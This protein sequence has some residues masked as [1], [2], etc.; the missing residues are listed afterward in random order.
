MYFDI[1][2]QREL[3]V[4]LTEKQFVSRVH[5]L[6]EPQMFDVDLEPVVEEVLEHWRK[7]ERT[8]TKNQL[9]Q[10]AAR[11]QVKLPQGRLNGFDFDVQEV[12][13]FAR[14]RLMRSAL[15]EATAYAEKGRFDKGIEAVTSLR[16]RFNSIGNNRMAPDILESSRPTPVRENVIS[17]G[18]DRLD[19]ALQGGVAA[20]NLAVALAP[21]SG[22]KTSFLCWLA[23]TAAEAGKKVYYVTLE[24]PATE[25]ESKLR[26][27]LTGVVRPSRNK[28]Q[29]TAKALAAKKARIRVQEHPPRTVSIDDLDGE[30]EEDTDLIL[31]DYAD[32]LRPPGGSAGIDYHDLGAIYANLKRVGLQRKVPIWTAS[33]VNRA[34]YGK[35]ELD[36]ED[37]EASL[38]KAMVSDQIVSLSQDKWDKPDKETGNSH[39]SMWI[40]KNR[41]GPRFQPIEVTVNWSLCRFE[42]GLFA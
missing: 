5:R 23:A 36:S 18:I 38:K 28:W 14:Y 32:Y 37:V 41:F 8:L 31:V 11:H 40:A 39:L 4:K 24:V 25:I 9:R 33:Q 21:T 17:T 42:R 2:Y 7:K 10:L 13:R 3:V 1:D 19:E 29:K 34:A 27:R 26:A 15:V 6:I 30:I 20:G 22:G 35:T 16:K 12:E